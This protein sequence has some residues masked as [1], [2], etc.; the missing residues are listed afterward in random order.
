ML[1]I[2]QT[3]LGEED[4]GI[5]GASEGKRKEKPLGQTQLSGNLT[6]LC[7]PAL[8]CPAQRVCV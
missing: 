5:G 8:P 2:L 1:A 4:G 6:G 3:A 7:W